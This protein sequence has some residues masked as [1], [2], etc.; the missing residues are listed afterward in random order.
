MNQ[1]PLYGKVALIANPEAGG[2]SGSAKLK[3]FLGILK[4][5]NI[6]VDTMVTQNPGHATELGAK[7]K[8]SDY[9]CLLVLGGDGTISEVSKGFYGSEIPV[10]TVPCGSGNDMA[11]ALGIPR[12][13]EK[14]YQVLL[15]ADIIKVD[16]LK[17]GD[18]FYI[19]TIGSGF[20]AEVVASVAR[21]S[22]IIH[23]PAAYFAAVFEVL[24]R[25]KSAR[26]KITVD[27]KDW[28]GDVSL[29][30]IN[31]PYRVGGGM[32]LTPDAILDDGLLD[33]GIVTTTSKFQLLTLL[34]KVYSGGHVT[35]PHV[36]IM[37]G[38]KI[39]VT[40]DRELMK[41]ADGEIVGTLPMNVEVIPGAINFMK[42]KS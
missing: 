26:Y 35:S 4:G 42:A 3:E 39:S 41:T 19:E 13:L 11:G 22:R 6:K 12:D 5:H 38:K 23:G 1:S 28:E 10:A 33:I 7:V 27:D 24:A 32:K 18:D 16:G 20:V 29:F 31:N 36:K 17:D 21:M 2:G 25:F 34:P 37:R 14:A 40:A 9:D 8:E 30:I 15:K